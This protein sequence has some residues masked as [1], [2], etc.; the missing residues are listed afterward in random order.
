MNR[1][2]RID[3]VYIGILKVLLKE[4]Q[5]LST[6][7]IW[8]KLMAEGILGRSESDKKTLNRALSRLEELG[9]VNGSGGRG[10]GGKRWELSRKAE[11]MFS[12]I[13]QRD[14]IGFL[15]LLSLLPDEYR[16]LPVFCSIQRIAGRIARRLKTSTVKALNEK[17][18]YQK[19]YTMRFCPINDEK[20]EEIVKAIIEEYPVEVIRKDL[21]IDWPLRESPPTGGNLRKIYPISLFYYDGNFYVGAVRKHG[22]EWRY[23]TYLLGSLKLYS[24]LPHETFPDDREFKKLVEQKRRVGMEFPGP[25][26]FLF[27]VVL[28]EIGGRELKIGGA[29]AFTTQLEARE[30]EDGSF[31]VLLVGYAEPRFCNEFLQ[32]D[33]IEIYPPEKEELKRLNEIGEVFKKRGINLPPP[34]RSYRKNLEN[35]RE[36]ISI[37]DGLIEKKKRATERARKFKIRE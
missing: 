4:P 17:F 12:Q 15:V 9:L 10:R 11:T 1:G 5:A 20:L 28:S 31:E 24:T 23:R 22:E 34:P 27:K 14:G 19:P 25:K 21:P 36:F 2:K 33:F 30:R 7:E 18:F 37:L 32:K 6:G 3:R 13:S 26:P 29:L 16:E 35:F 8:K